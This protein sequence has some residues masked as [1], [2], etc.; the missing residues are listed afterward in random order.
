MNS[1]GL[2][3]R[4][5]LFGRTPDM[6]FP[7][8]RGRFGTAG[9]RGSSYLLS[10]VL[11]LLLCSCGGTGGAAPAATTNQ[12]T[13]N[14]LEGLNASLKGKS[15]D[16]R[17]QILT[18]GAQKEGAFM[19]Y[20]TMNAADAQALID[21]FNKT[22][23][24]VKGDV[25]RTTNNDL[26]NKALTEVRAKKTQFDVIDISPESIVTYED[27]GAVVPYDSPSFDGLQQGMRDPQGYWAYMYLNGVVAAWNTQKVKPDEVPKSY[28]D[29]LKPRWKDKLSIDGQDAAWAEFIKATLGDAKGADFLKKLAAQNPHVLDGR[30]NQLNLLTAGEFD[31]SVALF[32]YSLIAAKK[33][34][35]PVDYAYLRPTMIA[36]EA[37]LADKTAPHPNAALLFADWLF[38][39]DGMQVMADQTG[40]MVPRTDVKLKNPEI[41]D[42][43]KGEVWVQGADSGKNLSQK[44]KEFS[45]L[46]KSSK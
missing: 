26:A 24:G 4:R 36:G 17:K 2:A 18:Q 12:A 43:T 19:L 41:A 44:E 16:E 37:L 46:F 5:V 42:Q 3:S 1:F 10:G 40:R 6:A 45:S 33:K 7:P 15:L 27:A 20:S 11:A 35:A 22:F 29:Y 31:L 32:D 14:T 28:D 9:S 25:F 38:S 21:G 23:P 13:P 8:S 39:K 34:G 30:T